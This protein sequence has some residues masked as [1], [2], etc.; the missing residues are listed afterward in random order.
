MID[1]IISHIIL[2]LDSLI[3]KFFQNPKKSVV[4]LL[5]AVLLVYYFSQALYNSFGLL[6][7]I[8][9]IIGCIYGATKIIDEP[10]RTLVWGVGYAISATLIKIVSQSLLPEFTGGITP[11]SIFSAIVIMY[12]LLRLFLIS[13]ALKQ[14]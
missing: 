8:G 9:Y 4:M 2:W 7:V 12:V 11:V 1:L 13:Q 3:T 10:R 5:I 14:Q 6:T